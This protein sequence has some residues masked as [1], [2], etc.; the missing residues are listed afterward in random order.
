MRLEKCYVCSST[1]YPGHG[2]T[3]VR[4][5]SK[6]FRFCRSKCSK[7]FKMKRNPRKMRWTKAYRKAHG[8]EMVVDSTFNFEKK[9]NVP[10]KYDRDL[11]A[12]TLLAMKRIAEIKERRERQFIKDRLKQSKETK[13]QIALAEVERGINLIAAPTL[14]TKEQLLRVANVSTKKEVETMEE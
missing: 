12:N 2:S 3:F 10:L 11:W 4:N 13:N 1:V 8:K 7:N 14:K 9:R 6:I 5:D